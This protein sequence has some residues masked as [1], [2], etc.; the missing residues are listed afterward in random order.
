MRVLITGATGF[1]GS[2]LV[3]ILASPDSA[4]R[5]VSP[6][7]G[8]GLEVR[9]LVRPTSDLT[10]LRKLA[11]ETIVGDLRDR[12]H[13]KVAARGA[14]VVLHLAALTRAR[15]EEEF[16]AVNEEGTRCLL[17]AARESGSCRRF[18]YISSLAAAGPAIDGRPVTAEDTPHPLT[19]YG[20]S[21]LA[22]ENACL[23]A[24]TD[25]EVVILRP[26][27]VYGPRDRDLLGFFRLARLG[28]RP[29]PTGPVRKIQMV[30]ALDLARAMVASLAASGA[31]GVYHVAEP[32]EYG[33][34]EIMDLMARAVGKQGV[35][36]P[37][38]SSLLRAA[39][40][41]S[42]AL[43]RLLDKPQIFDG[44]KVRELLAPGWLCET[45]RARTDLGFTAEIGLANGLSQTAEWYRDNG[46]LR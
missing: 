45:D 32:L 33:W 19:A 17:N 15:S 16:R 30:H 8:E 46:W 23:D 38:P 14:D 20:R 27:A 10:H 36:V 3:D 11:A 21:K 1:V 29:V 6:L 31:R 40:I 4:N 24:A 5:A 12:D 18:I 22:G 35:K 28:I 13:L 9:A 26:P 41:T 34:E 25:L 44:D 37:L 39:G 2:H 43:G 7:S 42:G